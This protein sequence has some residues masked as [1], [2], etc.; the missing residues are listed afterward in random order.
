MTER[1][2]IAGLQ[3]DFEELLVAAAVG[4]PPAARRVLGWQR[5]AAERRIVAI[6]IFALATVWKWAICWDS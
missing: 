2:S 4:R 5:F 6:A 3:I 1:K